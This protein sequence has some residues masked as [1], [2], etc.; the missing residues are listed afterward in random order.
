M[1]KILYII[2]A[3]A[4]LAISCSAPYH[5]NK[6]FKKD[7][8]YVAEQVRLRYPCDVVKKDTVN[9]IDTAW[10]EIEVDCPDSIVS[11]IDTITGEV[12]EIRVPVK[13]KA[14]V[15]EIT[16]TRIVTIRIKDMAEVYLCQNKNKEL[17]KEIT[18]LEAWKTRCLWT[19]GIMIVVAALLVLKKRYL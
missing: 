4:G 10:K 8:P 12:K 1:K 11:K 18:K 13:V 3:G 9:R 17:E 2:L 14:K 15:M 16:T 6:A 19:W 5:L 7:E